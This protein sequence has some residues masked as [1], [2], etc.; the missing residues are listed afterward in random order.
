M[1]ADGADI[2]A[3]VLAGYRYLKSLDKRRLSLDY[4]GVSLR[5]I[6]NDI[7]DGIV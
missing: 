5:R 3:K 4:F 1:L 6:S 2:D 7:L